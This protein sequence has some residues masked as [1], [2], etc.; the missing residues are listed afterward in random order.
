MTSLRLFLWQ[1]YV[2]W[3][4][5]DARTTSLQEQLEDTGLLRYPSITFCPKYS[6]E[7]FPGVME[8]LN[9][10]KSVTYEDIKRFAQTNYWTRDKTFKFVSHNNAV[11]N[12]SFP[13]NT[14]R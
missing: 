6:W 5:Y 14:A 8:L 10:N 9:N 12:K 4:K 11:D 2:A 7:T 1:G 3:Q 13:C